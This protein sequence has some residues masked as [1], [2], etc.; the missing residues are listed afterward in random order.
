M[1]DANRFGKKYA[2][3]QCGTKFYDLNKPLPI[4]PKCGADQTGKTA[5]PQPVVL[6]EEDLD[7]VVGRVYD[8]DRS[9]PGD[10]DIEV[11]SLDGEDGESLPEMEDME[12]MEDM[13]EVD[14]EL[15]IEEVEEE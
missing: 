9:L 7:A 8:D 13:D 2:C 10:L 1:V 4:C 12:N 11:A 15:T 14:E 6:T 3:Y 5:R